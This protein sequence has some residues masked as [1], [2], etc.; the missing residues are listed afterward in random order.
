MTGPDGQATERPVP[1]TRPRH[2]LTI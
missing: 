2:D 1:N